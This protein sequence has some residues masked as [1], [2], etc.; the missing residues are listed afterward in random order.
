MKIYLATSTELPVTKRRKSLSS[1]RFIL[2][3]KV[4]RYPNT[5]AWTEVICSGPVGVWR[6]GIC[7]RQK[8]LKWTTAPIAR[9]VRLALP[10]EGHTMPPEAWLAAHA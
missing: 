10:N 1:S 4:K 3:M 6:L 5:L 8:G 9:G 7:I 2:P